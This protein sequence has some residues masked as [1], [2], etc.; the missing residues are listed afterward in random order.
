MKR[1]AM[2]RRYRDTGPSAE[3]IETVRVRANERCEIGGEEIWFI[4]RGEDYHIHHRRPRG[5]GGTIRPDTNQ[6]PNLLL[7]CPDCHARVESRRGEAFTKGWLV[8]Q[9]GD[10]AQIAVLVDHGSRWVYL[11]ADGTYSDIPPE[12]AA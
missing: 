1:S 5:M 7:L 11:T 9:S 4:L 8:P 2:K 6:E 3:T 12:R 10:P